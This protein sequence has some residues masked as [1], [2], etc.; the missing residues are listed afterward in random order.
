[1]A[2]AL[3][4]AAAAGRELKVARLRLGWGQVDAAQ[5]AGMSTSQWSRLERGV[6]KHPT[7]DQLCRASR[8]VGLDPSFRLY[9]GEVPVNDRGQLPVLDRFEGVLGAALRMAREVG[10]AIPGDQRA[11]DARITD[12][13]QRASLDCEAR[14]EDMQAVGP[15]VSLKQRDDPD[16]GP[17]ILLVSRTRHNTAVL[18]THREA[19]RAMLPLDSAQLLRYLRAGRVPPAGGILVL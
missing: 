10:L 16:C 6:S 9:P 19:L 1:M 11:W 4:L 3:R 12:G 2:D 8:V 17:I 7:L 18:A 15:R 14:L 5:R 13:L